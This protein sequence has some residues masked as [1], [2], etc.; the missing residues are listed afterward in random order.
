VVRGTPGGPFNP[1]LPEPEVNN[2]YWEVVRRLPDNDQ[3]AHQWGY[4]A[5]NRTAWQVTAGMLAI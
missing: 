4:T 5:V 2:K 1:N 3:E